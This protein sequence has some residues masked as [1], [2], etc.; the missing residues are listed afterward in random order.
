M[1]NFYLLLI[2]NYYK[3]LNMKD[4]IYSGAVI[5]AH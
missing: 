3:I 2:S 5:Q 1:I 4:I